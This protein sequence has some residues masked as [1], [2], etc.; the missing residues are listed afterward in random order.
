MHVDPI[1]N[2]VNGVGV[3]L[4]KRAGLREGIGL[5]D[6]EASG[7]IGHRTGEENPPFSIQ[8]L[9]MSEVA[10]TIELSFRLAFRAV[11][12]KDDVLHGLGFRC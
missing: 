3:G 1:K 10:V 11:K 8:G 6:D 5:N 9:Q 4:S 12:P 2:A 7:L